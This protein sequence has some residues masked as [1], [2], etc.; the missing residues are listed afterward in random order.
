[1]NC[2]LHILRRTVSFNVTKSLKFNTLETYVFSRMFVFQLSGLGC[3]AWKP[4]EVD[5]FS[6]RAPKRAFG[7]QNY[8]PLLC[9]LNFSPICYIIDIRRMVLSV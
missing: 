9:V 8:K 3:L 4:K 5:N 7:N 6:K 2:A 1:M